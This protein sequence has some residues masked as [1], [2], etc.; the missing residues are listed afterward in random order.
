MI[1]NATMAQLTELNEYH[2]NP[3]VGNVGVIAESLR[4]NGQYRPVIV[5]RGTHTGR[6]NEVLA[7]NHT[8]KAA[9]SLRWEQVAVTYV[10]VDD[11]AAAR[12][13]VAD[14]HSSDIATNDDQVLLDLLESLPDLDGTTYDES[15]L[16]ALI[17]KLNPEDDDAE[18]S[19]SLSS[20]PVA[21]YTLVFDNEGQL[22]DWNAFL[23]WL[24]RADY[25]QD[26]ARTQA[27]RVMDYIDERGW[28]DGK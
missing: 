19:I 4:L 6:P 12:I 3:R 8:V 25:D 16:D 2:R 24:K 7:G 23:R 22:N 9:R 27:A 18:E 14:N 11:D 10:D 17:L 28:G 15:D 13:V 5:N 21:S 20:G 26:V 1:E